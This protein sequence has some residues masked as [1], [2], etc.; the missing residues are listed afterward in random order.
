MR[1]R[2][3]PISHEELLE[4]QGHYYRLWE[5]QQGNF[6]IIAKPNEEE[7]TYEIDEDDEGIMSYT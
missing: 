2:W 4:L 3:V 5:M 7:M 1:L 6:K